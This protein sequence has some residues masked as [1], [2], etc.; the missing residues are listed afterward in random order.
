MRKI[1]FLILFFLCSCQ[2]AFPLPEIQPVMSLPTPPDLHLQ[3]SIAFEGALIDLP[4]GQTYISYPYWRWSFDNLHISLFDACNAQTKYRFYNST[5]DWATG[6]KHFGDWESSA[7]EFVNTPLKKLGYDVVESNSTYFHREREKRRAEL[8]LSGRITDIRSNICNLLNWFYLKS[9]DVSA[10]N[11]YIK[12]EWEVYDTIADKVISKFTSDGVGEVTKPTANGSELILLRALEMATEQLAHQPEFYQLLTHSNILDNLMTKENKQR[13]LLLDISLKESTRPLNEQFNLLKRAIIKVGEDGTGFFLTPHGDILTSL[14]NVG[15][16]TR[17]AI[18]TDQ[19]IR[20]QANV[21]RT[22][23]RLQVA[24]LHADIEKTSYLK[25]AEEKIRT[26][27]EEVYTIGNPSEFKARSTVT[28]GNISSWRLAQKRN[29]N[30]IQAS[31]ST[32]TGY[33]GA[34]LLDA[35]GNV[36]G[37]HDGRNSN[38]STFSYF[39]P[40]HDIIRGLKLQLN[41]KADF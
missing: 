37:I 20:L 12:V 2:R 7:R 27:L 25:I 4:R 14:K 22:N 3:R 17:I 21:V 11:A 28:R 38:E 23:A 13:P 6:E 15:H 35:Y 30:F 5:A 34:P 26:A 31:I 9:E 1:V 16:A 40:I 33:A 32:T 8:L 24:L 18:E 10:G 39:I 19:G 41:H 36:L 29:Q